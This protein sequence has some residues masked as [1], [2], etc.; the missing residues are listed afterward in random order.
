MDT[1]S[2]KFK[3]SILLKILCLLLSVTFF[4]CAIASATELVA[5]VCVV[6]YDN[7]IAQ[8]DVDFFETEG[9]VRLFNS[10]AFS[11][12]MASQ[13][14]NSAKEN[15]LKG[16]LT[17]ICKKVYNDYALERGKI[18]KSEL[19]YAI[20]N[21]DEDY[22]AFEESATAIYEEL[23]TELFAS[24]DYSATDKP[25]NIQAAE[26]ALKKSNNPIDFNEYDYLVRPGALIESNYIYDAFFTIE[27]SDNDI[28]INDLDII[29]EFENYNFTPDYARKDIENQVEKCINNYYID[30]Y[31]YNFSHLKNLK[32][33]IIDFD[34][35]VSSNIDKIPK[36]LQ[37]YKRYILANGDNLKTKGFEASIIELNFRD[38]SFNQLCVYFEDDF[39]NGIPE[40]DSLLEY[41]SYSEQ[42]D[43]YSNL[44]KVYSKFDYKNI[45]KY[46][47]FVSLYLILAVVF[48]VILI[49][50]SGHKKGYKDIKLSAIDKLPTDIHFVL[51]FGV[52]FT[53][54]LGT[55]CIFIQDYKYD[56]L[57]SFEFKVFVSVSAVVTA[58]FADEFICSLNRIKKSG[59]GLL[60]RTAVYM[61]LSLLASGLRKIFK[62]LKREMAYKPESFKIKII[63]LFL[64]YVLI[65]FFLIVLTIGFAAYGGVIIALIP[66]WAI[67]AFNSFVCYWVVS[68]VNNLDRIIVASSKKQTVK[69]TSATTP[70]SLKILAEN[71]ETTNEALDEAVREAIKNEQMKTAL[72]TNVSHDLKTPLTSLIN[73][74]AL[75]NECDINDEKAMEYI[76]VI[77][78]QS[79]KLKRLIED[80]IEATK[81]STGNVQL[82]KAK[83]NLY[84]LAVQAVVEFIPDFEKNGNEIKLSEAENPPIVFADS[85]KTYRIISN[86][87][88]NA[89][90]Y[91]APNTRVYASVYDD[92]KYGYFEIKN[93]S[94]EPLNIS[95]DELT[96]RF[97][98]GDSSRANEG[99]GLGLS[100]AKDLCDLQNG[101]LML[102]IDG[103]LFKAIVKLPKQ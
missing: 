103:D 95:P 101:E 32:Y 83:L 63:L 9:F 102:T 91:S 10:D 97:V 85:T 42:A 62:A 64:L 73:Y 20:S 7:L 56:L 59:Q 72:I 25:K 28:L 35:N 18:I 46:I 8:K 15:A 87:L 48:F 67:I 66:L 4:A 57:T 100:I 41:L 58:L 43:S 5:G 69:F 47:I 49:K 99:N 31:G 50:L 24:E 89:K 34:G 79:D 53:L 14:N 26:A 92:S 13:V 29:V 22:Y 51:S 70:Q 80:L 39:E 86:L 90:K 81:V 77:N 23:T 84:E 74:S 88:S 3:N 54:I 40:Y 75:L 6:G 71:L 30:D 37:N 45:D 44:Y 27:S 19:E 11:L 55:L 33:Y 94:K 68:Y 2:K 1:R 38:K 76:S 96:E 82:N 21:W 98:R 12:T 60:K 17:N 78:R 93:I 61:I 65:N 16:E 52:P 36:N